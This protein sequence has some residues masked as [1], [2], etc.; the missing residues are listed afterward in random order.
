MPS[1]GSHIAP[2]GPTT[3]HTVSPWFGAPGRD[4][5]SSIAMP[6]GAQHAAARRTN[7]SRRW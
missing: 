1:E 5:F 2:T 3:L 4:A 6:E 7:T